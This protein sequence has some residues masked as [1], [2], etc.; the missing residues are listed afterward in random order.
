MVY[1]SFI[2]FLS[3][4]SVENVKMNEEIVK[5]RD[6]KW[7]LYIVVLLS[8]SLT[9]R[10]KTFLLN[11]SLN[12]TT[13]AA[14]AFPTQRRATTPYTPLPPPHPRARSRRRHLHTILTIFSTSS[15]QRHLVFPGN[16][17]TVYIGTCMC[18]RPRGRS[19][20]WKINKGAGAAR[21]RAGPCSPGH[22]RR[23]L[24]TARETVASRRA[25]HIISLWRTNDPFHRRHHTSV[26][27][28][29]FP[30]GVQEENS[31]GG[32]KRRVWCVGGVME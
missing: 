6:V 19:G 13:S 10:L 28:I 17:P 12:P 29:F 27:A 16:A 26:F 24:L 20:N 3:R 32:G 23:H 8:S 4:Y 14:T 30:R 7:F 9:H 2:F 31:H 18:V 25:C 21:G 1:L 22:R 11:I 5:G 15:Q